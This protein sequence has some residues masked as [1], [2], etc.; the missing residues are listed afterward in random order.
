MCLTIPK[1]VISF[2][3]GIATVKSKNGRQKIGSLIKVRKGDWALSQNNVI[4]SK[5]SAVQAKEINKLLR[6]TK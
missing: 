3:N 2:Q 1:Q 6:N 5:I 4:I